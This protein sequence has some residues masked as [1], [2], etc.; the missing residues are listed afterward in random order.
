MLSMAS[1]RRTARLDALFS[2]FSLILIFVQCHWALWYYFDIDF[3]AQK[4]LAEVATG[5][6]VGAIYA[7]LPELNK[8]YL[9]RKVRGLLNA[10]ATLV[11]FSSLAA[12][13]LIVGLLINRSIIKWPS[14]QANI[15]IGDQKVNLEGWVE[16]TTNTASAYGFFFNKNTCR[17]EI[18]RK[19]SLSVL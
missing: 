3:D 2:L 5:G 16:P 6:A 12:F 15:E 11:F 1:N 10:R 4:I 8:R 9:Q 7:F 13:L 19:I 17:S 14:G 18:S